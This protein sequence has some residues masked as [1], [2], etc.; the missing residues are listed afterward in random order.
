MR[1][2]ATC[3][4]EHAIKISDSYCSGPNSNHSVIPPNLIPSIQTS[5]IC[6]YKTAKLHNKKQFLI[7]FIWCDLIAKGFIISL[8]DHLSPPFLFNH[9][10][11]GQFRKLKGLEKYESFGSKIEVFWDLSNA[12]YEQDGPE[13][14]KGFYI[15]VL[16]DSELGLKLG[17]LKDDIE[18]ISINGVTQFS[19][20]SRSEHFSGG[21]LFSTKVRF[22]EIGEIHNIVIKCIGDDK[23]VKNSLFSVS[24]DG[25]DVIQVKR[26]Q[27]NFRGNQTIFIDGLLVDMMWDLNDWLFNLK[28]G[29]GV[30]MFRTRSGLHSRLWLEEKRFEEKEEERSGFS[31]LICACKYTD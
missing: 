23:G 2:I 26:L 24:I 8:S 27:W 31:L 15:S 4:S 21:G 9:Q 3:Y 10:N 6:I 25:K 20:I 1:N 7:E 30:F 19:L 5:V 29:Y 14:N 18:D 22:C 17:D 16:I 28:S 13:P 12:K 11:A